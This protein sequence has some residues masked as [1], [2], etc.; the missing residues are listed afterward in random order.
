MLFFYVLPVMDSQLDT[1]YCLPLWCPSS[2]FFCSTLNCHSLSRILLRFLFLSLR[3]SSFL[4]VSMS[5]SL[6]F[7]VPNEDT[8]TPIQVTH[9]FSYWASTLFISFLTFKTNCN[10]FS[11]TCSCQKDKMPLTTKVQDLSRQM[12]FYACSPFFLYK[13]VS[14]FFPL[15]VHFP[16][17]YYSHYILFIQDINLYTG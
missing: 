2:F 14:I 8:H 10:F 13:V 12:C 11:S 3:L 1:H 15:C 16:F 17:V 9:M 4:P 5:F 7:Y 6:S